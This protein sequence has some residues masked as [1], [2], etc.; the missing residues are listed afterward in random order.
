MILNKHRT[1]LVDELI[2]LQELLKALVESASAEHVLVKTKVNALAK[3]IDRLQDEIAVF[4]V[5][6]GE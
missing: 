5:V 1:A 3:E 6:L 4:N 2:Y